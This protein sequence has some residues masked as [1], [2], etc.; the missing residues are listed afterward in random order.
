MVKFCTPEI[1]GAHWLN[2][3]TYE[4]NSCGNVFDIIFADG[5][6]LVEFEEENGG[7]IKYLP[8]YGKG[9]Y[10]DLMTK[11]LPGHSLKDEITMAESK[12]FIVELNKYCEI[13][14]HGKRFDFRHLKF[15][16]TN[17][18]SKDIKILKEDVSKNPEL[19]FL[20]IDCSLI[21]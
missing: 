1:S 10:L 11:L 7:D 3:F 14:S 21:D 12:A 9:S 8:S 17:C 16:C 19:S 15:E 2:C 5:Y 20:K 13:G 4:C 18:K 6:D